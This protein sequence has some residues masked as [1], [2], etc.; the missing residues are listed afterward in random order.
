MAAAHAGARHG[1]ARAV[2][3]SRRALT[4]AIRK[5]ADARQAGP[6]RRRDLAADRSSRPRPDEGFSGACRRGI[7]RFAEK[8]WTAGGSERRASTQRRRLSNNPSPQAEESRQDEAQVEYLAFRLP[9]FKQRTLGAEDG[10]FAGPPHLLDRSNAP[11]ML[12]RGTPALVVC[13]GP[14]ISADHQE[15]PAGG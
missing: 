3:R 13:A 6:V 1:Q 7:S 4:P 12:L 15:I 11:L 5:P 14:R 10:V 9:Q 2:P 8:T